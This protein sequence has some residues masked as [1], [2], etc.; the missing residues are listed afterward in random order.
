MARDIL[1]VPI[2]TVASESTFSTG[3]RVLDSYRTSLSPKV[4]QA[5]ICTQDWI[6]KSHKSLTIE[7]ETHENEELDEELSKLT[8]DLSMLD[9]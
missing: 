3:G 7:D 2:S 5:L 6:R 9:L 1:A 8:G 4:V